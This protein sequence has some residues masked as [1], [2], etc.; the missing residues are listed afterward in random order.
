MPRANFVEHG[1]FS[2]LTYQPQEEMEYGSLLCWGRNELGQQ[3]RPCVF[4]LL[5][6]GKQI[7]QFLTPNKTSKQYY[8]S[9]DT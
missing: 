6:A 4:H 7:R 9:F 8:Y 1:N 5:P 2:V 3:L